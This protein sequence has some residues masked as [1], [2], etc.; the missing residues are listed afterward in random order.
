MKL[1]LGDC[2]SLIL[3]SDKDVFSCGHTDLSGHKSNEHSKSL[4]KIDFGG[5]KIRSIGAG[6]THSLASS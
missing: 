2:Y 5:E 3:T 6:F 4:K 1:S